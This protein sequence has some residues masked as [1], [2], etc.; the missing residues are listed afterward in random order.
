[1]RQ[2]TD[3][4]DEDDVHIVLRHT[5]GQGREFPNAFVGLAEDARSTGLIVQ[6]VFDE[7]EPLEPRAFASTNAYVW[8]MLTPWLI[9]LV[10]PFYRDKVYPWL[11]RHASSLW[12][13]FVDPTNRDFPRYYVANRNGI[14]DNDY[15]LTFSVMAPLKD[16]R[17][18]KLLVRDE[19]SEQEFEEAVC[20]FADFIHRHWTE[21]D[22][23]VPE[24]QFAKGLVLM[25]HDGSEIRPLA[26]DRRGN[27]QDR[28]EPTVDPKK[29]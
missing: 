12:R 26:I 13:H 24:M 16:G 23:P 29:H 5:T 18:A 7:E 22:D 4:G 9:F 3:S 25:E 21:D 15:S 8:M 11:K 14:I 27:R 19:C 6:E 2:P 1:M 10:Q 20:A 17:I 28:V